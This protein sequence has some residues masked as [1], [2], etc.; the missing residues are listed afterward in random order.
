MKRF[1]RTIVSTY[2]LG[3]MCVLLLGA[4]VL[5]VLVMSVVVF[6]LLV[7]SFQWMG[8]GGGRAC[9]TRIMFTGIEII[10]GC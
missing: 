7:F 3:V 4:V 5:L 8:L 9:S 10:F 6:R 1:L 2:I